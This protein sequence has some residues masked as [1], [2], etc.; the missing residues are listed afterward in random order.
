MHPGLLHLALSTPRAFDF[1]SP[2]LGIVVAL[3]TVML[4][5]LITF[6]GLTIL[7]FAYDLYVNRFEPVRSREW[8]ASQEQRSPAVVLRFTAGRIRGRRIGAFATGNTRRSRSAERSAHAGGSTPRTGARSLA[9]VWAH[10][11]IARRTVGL[12]KFEMA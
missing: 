3:L 12:R 1:S 6:A 5:N 4:T 8:T 9:P 11:P 2:T 10:E 7:Y